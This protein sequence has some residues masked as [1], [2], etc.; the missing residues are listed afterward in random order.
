LT[1]TPSVAEKNIMSFT[2]RNP[3]RESF[4]RFY[5]RLTEL[6]E[7]PFRKCFEVVGDPFVYLSA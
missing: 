5:M 7:K 3:I 2:F 1:K 6:F 4:G